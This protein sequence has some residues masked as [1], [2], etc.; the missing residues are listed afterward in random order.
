MKN[1]IFFSVM[2]LLMLAV[3]LPAQVPTANSFSSYQAY[4]GTYRYGANP[5]YYG[6]NWSA[7]NIA[8]LAMGSTSPNVKG[9]GV[10]SFRVP[11]YDDHLTLYGLNAEM[12]KIQYYYSL[13]AGDLTAFVGQPHHTK[14][15][16][17]THPGSPEPAKTFKGMYQPIW[18]DA[19]QTQINPNNLY[20]KYLYDVVNMYGSYIKFWEVMNE[21]DFTYGGGGWQGDNNPPIA[22]SWFDYDPTAADLVNLRAPVEHYV[23]MLRISWEVIK[24]LQPNDYVCIG[25]L[26]YK[27]FLDAVLRNTDNPTDGSVTSAYP[28]KGGAYFDVVS[29]HIYPMYNLRAWSNAIGGF[30][31]Y[32]HSDAAVNAFIN[33]MK[34]METVNAN[35]GYNGSTYPKK[36]FICSETGLSRIMEGDNWG[37]N[38]GQRNYIMKTNIVA[39]KHKIGQVYWFQVGD[40]SN[41][42]AAFDQMGMYFHFGWNTPFNATKADQ[43][44]GLKTTSDILYGRVYDEAKTNTLNLPSTVDGGAFR[45][46]DGSYVYALWA[47]TRTDMSETA[48]VTYS[49]PS[50]AFASANVTRREWNAS[51]TNASTTSPKTNIVLTGAVAFFT[52]AG[53]TSTPTN[54]VP[55]ANAG[56]DQTITL[57]TSSVTLNGTG[58]DADGNIT[59]Y[60]WSQVSGPSASAI[61]SPAN[62]QTTINNL[63]QGVYQFEI[64]VTDN[65]NAIGRDTVQVTVNAATTSTGTTVKVEAE[66]YTAMNGVQKENTADAGGGQNVG[67][68]D[69]GDWMDYSVNPSTS[70]TFSFKFRV[71]AGST[72]AKF[73][74][75][76]S[77]GTVLAT[78]DVPAT[79]GWQNWQ[80]ITSNVNL[81]AG[82]QTIRLHSTTW[83]GWNIN[84]FE[85]SGSATA[86]P[87]PPPPPPPP[88]SGSIIKIE[89]EA[90]TAMHG[91][92][93]ENTWDAGGGQNVGWIDNGD[94]MDYSVNPAATGSYTVRF[95][96]A[97]G[98][99]GAQFQVRKS[100]GTVLTTV[101][102]PATGGWQNWQTVTATVSL[103]AGAQTLRLFSNTWNG[104]NIN[105]MEIEGGGSTT[106]T[107]PST[108]TKVEAENYTAMNGVQKENTADAGGGQNVGWIDNGDWMDYSVTPSVT[109]AYSFKFRLAA[110]STGAQFQVRRPDGTV[111]TTVNVPATGGWQN[112]Q[113]VTATVNLTAGAQTLRLFSTTWNGWNINWFEFTSPSTVS[114]AMIG[115]A[116]IEA[117]ASLTI[118]PNPVADKFVLKIDNAK[119]G[120]V[121][122][123]ITDQNGTVVKT[124]SLNKTTEGVMQSYLSVT[125]LPAGTYLLK[126]T[127]DGWTSSRQLIKQ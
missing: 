103:S 68:I 55:V 13:G 2:M 26:G 95:R 17:V 61:L 108:T 3:K 109:G 62:A 91:V 86:P 49:F 101:N 96:V 100:D 57:P 87:P 22:G 24:K 83:N 4:T 16:T 65:Q 78:V 114:G 105:W 110:G 113:T 38:I 120:A 33:C 20:A 118:N 6:G 102:V 112:W 21:P 98:A 54:Q 106:T 79:G 107:V 23:R 126:A 59:S 70:G 111:L 117:D 125:D 46:N 40:G 51:E 92:Q 7:Q 11:L 64:R 60:T 36:Q 53:G 29:F 81:S 104:W 43:G 35:H 84:W 97:S 89:A 31:H 50:T 119:T 63:L 85:F 127:M 90:F 19:A 74:V 67:W 14:K 121:K 47:K 10:K 69:N 37:S 8:A 93:T 32:R 99:T 41:S 72:G 71:A 39:Q 80:T 5:G 116:E 25:G 115:E 45:G 123:E 1:R 73:E 66:N 77:D 75:R 18:L 30:E 9:A 56:Q 122:V 124:F 52:E 42:G 76:K 34:G 15:E 44:I 27:S 82:A 12:P 88:S 94:W 28:L 58:T 48:S